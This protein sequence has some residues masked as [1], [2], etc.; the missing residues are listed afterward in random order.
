MD[1]ALK[2]ERVVLFSGGL[3]SLGGAVQEIVV[4][5][6]PVALVFHQATT[7]LIN[8]HRTLHQMLDG[9]AKGPKPLH[10]TVRINKAKRLNHEY[11]QRSR[12]FL[13]AS[14]AAAVARMCGLHAIRFYE[15]GTVSL[16]LP[17]AREVVGAKATRTTHP[18]VLAGFSQ[19]FSLLTEMAFV[20]D[21]GFL[22][23]T[24]EDVI[25][26]IVD[27]ECGGMIEWSTSCAHTWEMTLANPHCGKCSQCIDR[28]FAILAAG[29]ANFERAC[30]YGVDLLKGPREK[31]EPRTMLAS[32]VELAQQVA[33]MSELDFFMRFGEVARIV[34][35]LGGAADQNGRKVYEL[36]RRHAATIGRV[37]DQGLAQCASQIR[38]RSLPERCL[39]RMVHDPSVPGAAG[40]VSASPPPTRKPDDDAYILRSNSATGWMANETRSSSTRRPRS[41]R[42][43]R[44]SLRPC[45][46]ARSVKTLSRYAPS[47]RN[48]KSRAKRRRREQRVCQ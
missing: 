6:R 5:G 29:A 3:D 14:L 45:C 7:K 18:R 46:C 23:K 33:T 15:N 34:R 22:W 12:S 47:S 24:K 13:Y 21:N 30:S 38:A 4:E 44:A 40:A 17:I 2:P 41:A 8:R 42:S 39:L 11:T 36:Y 43:S 35:H 9:R 37:I 31:G 20:V 25:R 26:A 28:R 16:N 32:Y 48:R 27:A 1:Y 19:L 10:V